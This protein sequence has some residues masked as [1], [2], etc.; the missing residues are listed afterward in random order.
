MVKRWARIRKRVAAAAAAARKRSRRLVRRASRRDREAPSRRRA[1]PATAHPV[2]RPSRLVSRLL[3]A[4]GAL[5]VVAGAALVTPA[6]VAALRAQPYF[7]VDEIALNATTHVSRAELLAWAGLYDGVGI[8]DVDSYATARRLEQ[9]PWIMRARV[10]RELPRRVIVR[11]AERR[12]AAIVLLDQPYWVDARGVAFSP[13]PVDE[14]L[15]LPFITGV[16]AALVGGEAPYARHAIRRA[17]RVVRTLRDAGLSFRVS[18][19]HIDRQE[20]ITVFPV[21]PHIALGFGWHAL[22][23]RVARLEK[24]LGTFGGRTAQVRAIDLTAADEAVIRLRVPDAPDGHPGGGT[25]G[26]LRGRRAT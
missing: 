25:A 1:I 23:E 3:I 12:P 6:I 14:P 10:R 9:H 15:A 18:E 24:V 26:K 13:L 17:L 2:H 5:G 21:E 22:P 4:S 16:E 8:W 20:G 19:V 7:A 11:V